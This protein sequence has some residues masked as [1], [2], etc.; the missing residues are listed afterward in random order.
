MKTSKI[1]ELERKIGEQEEEIKLLKKKTRKHKWL[2][3]AS[4]FDGGKS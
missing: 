2:I 3:L 1:K 4:L